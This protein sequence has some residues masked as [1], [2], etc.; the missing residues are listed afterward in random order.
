MRDTGFIEDLN[1]ELAKT[2]EKLGAKIRWTWCGKIL[3]WTERSMVSGSWAL[4]RSAQVS[5]CRQHT[6]VSLESKRKKTLIT[7]FKKTVQLFAFNHLV[8][9]FLFDHFLPLFQG[10]NQGF[11]V[12]RIKFAGNYLRVKTESKKGTF[13][14]IATGLS[15]LMSHIL[16]S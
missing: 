7:T 2:W 12:T 6:S 4:D 1:E 11:S 8:N 16:N 13:R 15:G 5:R 3:S 9:S 14:L 10:L